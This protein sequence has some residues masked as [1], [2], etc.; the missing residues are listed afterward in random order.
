MH[1][2]IVAGDITTLKSDAIV[3]AANEQMLGGSGVDGAIHKAAGSSLLAACKNVREESPGIRCRTGEC[4]LTPGFDLP[5]NFVIHTVG[6]IW[7]GGS[8]REEELLAK[9][10]H[11]C[12]SLAVHL[13]LKTIAFPAISCGAFG[14]PLKQASEIA[15]ET[16]AS[17]PSTKSSLR[18]VLVV[19]YNRKIRMALKQSLG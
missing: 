18:L 13:G 16:I 2:H 6:P 19:A 9:C 7:R 11:E 1:I 5:A 14:Y 10:Y 15:I 12:L 3:N 17:F 4:R 8:A